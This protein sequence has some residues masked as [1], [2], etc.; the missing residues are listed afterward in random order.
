VSDFGFAV[1]FYSGL[2]YLERALQSLRA[3]STSRWRAVV[4]DDAGPEPESRDL[5]RELRDPRISYVRND[6]NLGLAENWNRCLEL[7]EADFVTLLHGDDELANDYAEV[8]LD[9]HRRY[10]DAAA[11]HTGVRVVGEGGAPIFSF[12]D[13]FKRFT[14]PRRRGEHVTV[15]DQGL[16]VVLRGQ[17]I[18]FPSLSYKAR[19]LPPRP[20]D[21]SWRQV[22][23]LDLLARLLFDGHRI[24]GV[25]RPAYRYRRHQRSQTA[26]LTAS[27]ER[28][29]EEFALYD[30]I[31][32]RAR[33][34]G[35][36]RSAAVARR[37]RIVRAHVAYRALGGALR[38]NLREAGSALSLLHDR[39]HD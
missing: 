25:P 12:P 11:V 7:V 34:M 20:F 38:G 2:P 32:Q 21:P 28:F 5:V 3:Q 14:G 29:R 26:V 35:W 39:R 10:P 17:F 18:F 36:A 31:A 1:P 30:L 15:G 37:A 22:L 9:A 23:D 24:V 19:L 16:A 33:R 8:V 4:V 13:F 27:R 6:T